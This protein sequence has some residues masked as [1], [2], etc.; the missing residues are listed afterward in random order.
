M[1]PPT[2]LEVVFVAGFPPCTHLTV[3]GA[4]DWIKKGHYML[5]DALELWTSCLQVASWSGA[6]FCI[7]NPVGALSKHMMPPDQMF[8]P[9]DYAGYLDDEKSKANEAY[10]KKTCLWTGNGFVMPT[11][12]RIEPVL[13]SKMWKVPPGGN[14]ANI[15]SETPKGF[16]QAV[17]EANR[18]N[19]IG[20]AVSV[21]AP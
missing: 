13:G 20:P 7:E 8:D 18:P 12:K 4:R 16:A 5:T 14:R 10:T 17:F 15:R 11:P 1:V 2:N 19:P 21:F 3:A 6:P 9:C